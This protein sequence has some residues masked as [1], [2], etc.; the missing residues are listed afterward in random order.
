[1]GIQLTLGDKEYFKGVPQI[2]YEGPNSRNPL[3]FKFYD[4][5][6]VVAG[7]KMKDHFRFAV[8]Y[9]HSFCGTGADPFGPGT[10]IFPWDA[11]DDPIQ[12]AKDKLDA[13]FEFFTKL[14]VEYYCFHDR[15]LAPEGSS[16]TESED[17]LHILVQAAKK[18]SRN[19]AS[20]CCGIPPT[21]FHIRAT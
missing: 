17:N 19:P 5:E 7:K 3:A 8:A 18:S 21:S 16:V 14:G 12:A 6:K 20:S 9:W 11:A 13:A 2:K 15:D 1:M 4:P 10:K